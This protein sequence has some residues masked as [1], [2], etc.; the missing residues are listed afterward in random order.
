MP[1]NSGA[2][3]AASTTG[4]ISARAAPEQMASGTRSAAYRTA[5][6]GG[7]PADAVG[8]GRAVARD[9]LSDHGVDVGV[10]TAQPL[11]HDLGVGQPGELVESCADIGRPC[12][13]K[14]WTKISQRI[15]SSSESVPLKSK[16]RARVATGSK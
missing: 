3:P 4:S 13:A 5:S 12:S 10:V 7:A 6:R 14:R 16:I 11:A 2:R 15:G 9:S 8:D 1:R